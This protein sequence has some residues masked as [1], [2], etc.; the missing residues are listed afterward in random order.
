MTA[1]LN[2]DAKDITRAGRVIKIMKVAGAPGMDEVAIKLHT[3]SLTYAEQNEAEIWARVF[4]ICSNEPDLTP[5]EVAA[6]V[7]RR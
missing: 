7:M 2:I 3:S 5:L 1:H 4:H 6:R